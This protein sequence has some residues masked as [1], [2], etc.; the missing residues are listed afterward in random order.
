MRLEP[1]NVTILVGAALQVQAEGGPHPQSSIE[2]ILLDGD[3]SQT[4]ASV[5][6]SGLVES[7][8]L[9][10]CYGQQIYMRFD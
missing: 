7:S 9:G 3:D 5:S 8:A 1:R 4:V 2:Y 10:K 6:S